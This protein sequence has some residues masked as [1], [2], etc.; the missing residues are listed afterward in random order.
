M[1]LVAAAVLADGAP[2]RAADYDAPTTRSARDVLPKE[3]LVGSHHRIGDAVMADGYMHHFTVDSTYGAFETSGQ[4]ALRKLLAEI[5]AI[6]AL[7]DIKKTKAW[8]DAV[9]DSA[10]GPFRLAKNLITNPVDTVAG[11]PKGA[12]KLLEEA[13]E[14]VTNERDPSDDPAY[15]KALLVSGRKRDYASQLGVD[16]YSSNSVLQKELNSV[17]WAAAIGNL[18]V[19]AALMP[20]GGTAGTVVTS[21]R[22]GNALNDH[23]KNQ[24]ANRLRIMNEE[25]LAAMGIPGDLARRYLDHPHYSPRHDTIIAE[26]LTGLGGAAGRDRFLQ[27]ALG[28]EDEIEANFFTNVAQILRGYHASVAPIAEIHLVGGRLTVAQAR[29]GTTLVPLPI[30][31]LM[32]TPATARRVD[33]LT[34][35]SRAPG[36]PGTID[37]WLTG[38][39][40]PLARRELGARGLTVTDQVGRRIEIID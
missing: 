33:E 12:Y 40:S 13:G 35:R 15:K 9:A 36:S 29:N 23:L 5:R 22:F 20:V 8:A 31:Y 34:A 14:A 17:A 4:G 32:W 38:T 3:M 25:K 24:P 1:A 10:S 6:A 26:A 39:V 11:V 16:V 7:R 27:R 19:S 28:A 18:S 21:V 37:V 2:V 30:D